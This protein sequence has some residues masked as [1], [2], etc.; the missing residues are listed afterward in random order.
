MRAATRKA[1]AIW[2]I[3][4]AF[5][6]IWIVAAVMSKP[7]HVLDWFDTSFDGSLKQKAIESGATRDARLT[8]VPLAIPHEV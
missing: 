4:Y 5:A 8:P 1:R 6:L 7:R 2:N 3:A